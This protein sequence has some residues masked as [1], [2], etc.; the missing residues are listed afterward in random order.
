MLKILGSKL[1][2]FIYLLLFLQSAN[3]T[4]IKNLLL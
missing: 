4:V 2:L 3:F 1:D